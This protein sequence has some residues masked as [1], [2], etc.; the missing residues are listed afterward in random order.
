MSV[1]APRE[2]GRPWAESELI[3]IDFDR[4]GSACEN[5]QLWPLSPWMFL[6]PRMYYSTTIAS[7]LTF[8][9]ARRKLRTV[10]HQGDAVYRLDETQYGNAEGVNTIGTRKA[11]L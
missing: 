5:Y 11:G 1:K 3:T 4:A 7:P 2:P 10:F 9:S 6:P 8:M